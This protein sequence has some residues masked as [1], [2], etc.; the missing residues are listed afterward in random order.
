MPPLVCM[1][2][3]TKTI[4]TSICTAACTLALVQRCRNDVAKIM[5]SRR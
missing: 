2:A 1:T 4:S 3:T 5:A